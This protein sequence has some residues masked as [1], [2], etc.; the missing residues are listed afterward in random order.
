MGADDT[1]GVNVDGGK[2][3][4]FFQ[5]VEEIREN[6]DRIQASVDD[7]KHKHSAILSAPQTDES[8]SFKILILWHQ[9]AWRMLVFMFIV[10]FFKCLSF[11]T[12]MKQDLEDLMS[13]IKKTANKV[14][15]KLKGE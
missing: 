3:E 11:L 13:N 5:E 7:V 14:R 1:V 2:M 12:E 8:K 6:I 10:S 4:E 9:N 15:A